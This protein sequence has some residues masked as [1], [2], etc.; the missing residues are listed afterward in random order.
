MNVCAYFALRCRFLYNYNIALHAQNHE[1]KECV[2]EKEKEEW[3]AR[4]NV[5]KT[6]NP[7]GTNKVWIQW[8][9]YKYNKHHPFFS[10]QIFRVWKHNNTEKKTEERRKL[11]VKKCTCFADIVYPVYVLFKLFKYIDIITNQNLSSQC[12]SVWICVCVCVC[13]LYSSIFVLIFFCIPLKYVHNV[14]T[15]T[16][17][18]LNLALSIYC[19]CTK[20][21]VRCNPKTKQ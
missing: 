6:K 3:N 17:L 16:K 21:C 14:Y 19:Y 9:W 20:I 18:K 13:M 10:L 5:E 4:M 11:C 7:K 2:C 15:V 12:L 8:M 1:K